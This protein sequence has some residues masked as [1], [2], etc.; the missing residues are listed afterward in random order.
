MKKVILIIEKERN[1]NELWGRIQYEGNLIVE[2]APTTDEL[3]T[4]LK[5]ILQEF[6]QISPE[7]VEFE[8]GLDL[9]AL[10]HEKNFL[11]LSAVADRL[12]INRSLLAQ[13]AAGIKHPSLERAQE[14]ENVIH[15]FG[16][17][18]KSVKVAVDR[19]LVSGLT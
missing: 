18:L 19:E 13:Y 10:F 17:E 3:Q 2:S 5:N 14:I 9:T 11:T 6:H 16:N 1:S 4:K 12:G 15:S 7:D 8:I